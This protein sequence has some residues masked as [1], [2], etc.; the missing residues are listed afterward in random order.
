VRRGIQHD[1]PSL[2]ASEILCNTVD[3][4]GRTCDIVRLQTAVSLDLESIRRACEKFCVSRLR[5]FGS[6]LTDRFNASQS[7][8]DF[9]V[10]FT[11]DHSDLFNASFS[12][13]HELEQI[14]GR[15]VDLVDASAVRNPYFKPEAF[16]TAEELYA[17]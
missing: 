3:A 10:D 11:P 9:L 2:D 14:V 16:S 7:D 13:K 1:Q 12:L 17:A 6:V 15:K 8:V 4:G 5:I